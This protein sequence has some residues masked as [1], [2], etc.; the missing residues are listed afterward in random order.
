[1]AQQCICVA[2]P[3]VYM[4]HAGTCI[5]MLH[6]LRVG[7]RTCLFDLEYGLPVQVRDKYLEDC[8]SLASLRMTQA[9]LLQAPLPEQRDVIL[10]RPAWASGT[11]RHWQELG[12]NKVDLPHSRVGSRLGHA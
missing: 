7:L 4:R 3:T 10:P 12:A 11:I 1:M 8:Y 5:C 9:M 2:V 6:V